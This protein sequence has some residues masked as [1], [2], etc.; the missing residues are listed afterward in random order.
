MLDPKVGNIEQTFALT[1][2][3]LFV[4]SANVYD[5]AIQSFRGSIFFLYTVLDS[6][7]WN[8]ELLVENDGLRTSTLLHS[9]SQIN[10]G[11]EPGCRP[12]VS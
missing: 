11:W 12:S 8:V 5:F 2:L 6:D 3:S 1:S 10:A 4:D 7:G 9:T